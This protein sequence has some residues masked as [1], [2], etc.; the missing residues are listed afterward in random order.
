MESNLVPPGLTY[1][2]DNIITR[3]NILGVTKEQGARWAKGLDLPARAD[4]VFFAG[5]GYQYS[6]Q[7]EALMFE[8]LGYYG[9]RS[10]ENKQILTFGLY[11]VF[12]CGAIFEA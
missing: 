11:N 5:C 12:S 2:A 1:L 6:A 4:N 8:L 3:Q 9:N 7:L 10:D